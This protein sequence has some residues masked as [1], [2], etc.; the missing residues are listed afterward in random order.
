[1]RALDRLAATLLLLSGCSFVNTEI[2]Y[3]DLGVDARADFDAGAPVDGAFVD[4]TT[5]DATIS[6]GAD[7][8]RAVLVSIGENVL[9]PALRDFESDAAALMIATEALRVS[10]TP[11]ARDAAR[12]AWRE[13]MRSWE[14]AEMLQV[15]PA[16]LVT[17]TLG[18]RALRDEIYAWPLLNRCRVDQETVED[19]HADS[20]MLAVESV[21]VRGLGSIEYLLFFDAPTN[22]CGATHTINASGSWAA[23]DASI[24]A[25]RRAA[26][27]HSAAVLVASRATELRAAWDPSGENFLANFRTA[28]DGSAVYMTAQ[29]GLNAVSDALFYLYKEVTDDKVGIPMGLRLECPTDLCPEQIESRYAA[30][31]LDHIRANVEAFR[32]VY[33]GA[34]PEFPDAPGFDDLLRSVGA[35][36][37]DGRIQ[38]GIAAVFAALALVETPFESA[39]TSDYPDALTL[40][41]ALREIAGLFR[42]D[43]LTLLDLELPMRIEGDND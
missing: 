8:T 19:A 22:G 15:G 11:E 5:P 39:L 6:I 38:A 20:T 35:G 2:S 10:G 23:L 43:V 32:D 3:R 33:L 12:A 1:M 29:S 31:S 26:Y 28:G 34:P 37:L 40:H 41:T 36:E 16:G 21:N 25:A 30:A 4:G 18:G 27:A 7:A 9:M 14:R 42:V 17:V 13:A 24:I